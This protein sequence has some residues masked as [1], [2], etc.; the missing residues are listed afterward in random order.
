MQVVFKEN[1]TSF[2]EQINVFFTIY[3]SEDST[4]VAVK[5]SL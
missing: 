2:T 3:N 5:Y 4:L 1:L